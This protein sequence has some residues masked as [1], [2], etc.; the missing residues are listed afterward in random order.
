MG[1]FSVL[2]WPEAEADP[3]E[4]EEHRAEDLEDTGS[5]SHDFRLHADPDSDEYES[6]NIQEYESSTDVERL[7]CPLR[8]LCVPWAMCDHSHT[9]NIINQQ[10]K[11][12]AG[13][14]TWS[15]EVSVRR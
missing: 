4:H 5:W 1:D 10:T 14:E 12:R 8:G 3:I 2:A 15:R 11:V 7:I 9:I 6:R 13:S